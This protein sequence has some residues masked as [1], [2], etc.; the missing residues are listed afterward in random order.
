MRKPRAVPI[1]E[2]SKNDN[3]CDY[4]KR[5]EKIE[6]VMKAQRRQKATDTQTVKL[7]LCEKGR[8]GQPKNICTVAEQK[9]ANGAGGERKAGER[10]NNSWK[11]LGI[12]KRLK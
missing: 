9:K 6:N 11:K 8:D 12:Q 1:A 2:E 3:G 7:K 10:S 5:Y 4:G